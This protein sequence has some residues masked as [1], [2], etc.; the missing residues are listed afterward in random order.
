MLMV[1]RKSPRMSAPHV[2]GKRLEHVLRDLNVLGRREW[3]NRYS[4]GGKFDVV[5]DFLASATGWALHKQV[6]VGMDVT[7]VRGEPVEVRPLAADNV[8]LLVLN[9]R[10]IAWV[11]EATV[12]HLGYAQ[13]YV[14]TKAG[15]E[16]A[17]H[18]TRVILHAI[19]ECRLLRVDWETALNI[20]SRRIYLAELYMYP[21]LHRK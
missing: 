18:N 8:L 12:T 15:I 4:A 19:P 9:G 20:V 21:S 7:R 11:G 10:A 3:M 16:S 6:G 2:D 14:F 5:H 17:L 13:C 1:V